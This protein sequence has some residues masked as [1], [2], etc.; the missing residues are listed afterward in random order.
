M[1]LSPSPPST[2]GYSEKGNTGHRAAHENPEV[3]LLKRKGRCGLR[4]RS[5][6]QSLALSPEKAQHEE[7]GL[8]GELADSGS[9]AGSVPMS[10]GHLVIPASKETNKQSCN[11]EATCQRRNYSLFNRITTATGRKKPRVCKPFSS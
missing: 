10:L 2:Q 3:L 6:F 5:N 7:S 4:A 8:L 11:S 9:G 1:V